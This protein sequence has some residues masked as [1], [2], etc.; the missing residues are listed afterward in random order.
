MLTKRMLDAG[1]KVLDVIEAK[2][3][4]G[5]GNTVFA[6]IDG[7]L[8]VNDAVRDVAEDSKIVAPEERVLWD[9]PHLENVMSFELRAGKRDLSPTTADMRH[10]YPLVVRRNLLS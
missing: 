5:L 1:Q 8:V 9:R 3:S 2:R 6:A 10:V 7:V 4:Q